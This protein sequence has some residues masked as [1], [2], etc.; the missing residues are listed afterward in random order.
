MKKRA[1][2]IGGGGLRG[3][4]GAGVLTTLCKK[5]GPDYFD[6]VYASSVGVFAA[7]FFLSN[8]P[9]T[10]EH[11]W[12]NLVSGKQLVNYSHLFK[13]GN[14]LDLEYLV[15]IFQNEKS[16]LDIEAVMNS[17]S[18]IIYTLTEY[19]SGKETHLVPTRQNIFD[20]MRASAALPLV[21]GLVTINSKKYIDGGISNNLPVHKALT[22]GCNEILVVHNKPEK[23]YGDPKSWILSH[24]TSL[25]LPPAIVHLM[26]MSKKQMQSLE[27]E[28]FLNPRISIIRPDRQLPL[29]SI[30]DTNKHRI[31]TSFNMGAIDAKDF[32]NNR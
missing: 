19:P 6:A 22:D 32:L 5:L 28:I 2:V 7:T 31:N 10:I 3:A 14:I 25:Y 21:Y 18:T 17:P 12:R 1:L 9:D 16:L 4:Y 26:K 13:K 15:K 20:L 8:Q 23:S 24:I 29:T 27:K 11:T 30:L